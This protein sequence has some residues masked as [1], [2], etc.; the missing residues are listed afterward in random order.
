M[1]N[2]MK[3]LLFI[4]L[5]LPMV[6]SCCID[7]VTGYKVDVVFR[8]ESS[9]NVT[10]EFHRVSSYP[11]EPVVIP[12]GESRTF[13]KSYSVDGKDVEMRE[14]NYVLVV[15]GTTQVT[16]EGL[17]TIEHEYFTPNSIGSPNSYEVTEFNPKERYQKVEHTLTD[18]D[19]DY[20][21]SQQ[22]L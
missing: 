5:A 7:Y 4:L 16:F 8:N 9:Y 22:P 10:L 20:A 21:L 6:T 12:A 1:V 17:E 11:A 14:Y 15:P 19:Y 13:N 18:E 3:K 2:T